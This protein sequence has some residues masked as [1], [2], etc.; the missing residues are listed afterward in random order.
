[1][2]FKRANICNQSKLLHYNVNNSK[3]QQNRP[4]DDWVSYKIE[5]YL[6]G[7]TDGLT[8]EVPENIKDRHTGR[9]IDTQRVEW[10][11]YLSDGLTDKR[12]CISWPIVRQTDTVID[13][14][15]KSL[16][17]TQTKRDSLIGRHT[18]IYTD[19]QSEGQTYR[20]T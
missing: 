6:N 12:P 4:T 14:Q 2:C 16:I 7:W 8:G 17:V 20:E 1:V 13:R 3:L 18:D 11:D 19:R 10:T 5:G 15:T 9:Y